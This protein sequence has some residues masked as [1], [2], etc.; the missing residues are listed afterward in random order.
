MHFQAGTSYYDTGDYEGALREFRRSYDLSQRPQLFY[1]ISLAYE[2]LNDL[3]NAVTYLRRFL[4]EVATIE[5]RRTYEIRLQ[6]IE[7]R[8]EALR[9]PTTAPPTTAPATTETPSP[10]PETRPQVAPHDDASDASEAATEGEGTSASSGV[11]VSAW[12]GFGVGGAG[13]L[14]GTTFGLLALSEDSSLS[15]GCGATTSCTEDDVSTMKTYQLMADIG[16]ALG[17]AGVAVGVVMLLSAEDE[18]PRDTAFVVAPFVSETSAGAA[19]AVA[20]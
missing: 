6:N 10:S 12:I 15:D 1:N 9:A 20:F 11:P 7:R 8:L 2:R 16:F 18:A 14:A 4:A 19:A 17:L 13:L 3:E 5:D